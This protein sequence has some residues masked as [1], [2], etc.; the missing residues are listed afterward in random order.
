MR[1]KR[2]LSFAGI[3]ATAVLAWLVFMTLWLWRNQERVVFQPPSVVPPD[4]ETGRRVAFPAA[5]G[6]PTFGFLVQANGGGPKTVV[7]AFHGNADLAVWFIPWAQELSRRAGVTVLVPEYRGYG[8]AAG[9]ATYASA[10]SDALG[11][12]AYA[13]T[14]KPSRVVLYGHS[15]G[16]AIAV[17]LADTMGR[18]QP[19][20]LVLQSPFTSAR[21]MASR[22]LVL[23][24]PMVWDRITR[25][26]WD[27]RASVQRLDI[28]VSVAHGRLDVT[29]PAR[30]GRD[31]FE[32]ARRKG[33]HLV[34]A[35]AGHNDVAEA[36]GEDY[37]RWLT[38]AVTGASA[39][40]GELEQQ[41]RRRLP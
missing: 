37:W 34:V 17:Q 30:M 36:G 3:V 8:G 26:H 39:P 40:V 41:G 4:P 6:S 19:D 29:V 1:V 28:P 21:A 31:V 25:F 10:A 9:S 7:I 38:T 13:R 22:M 16:T 23:V 2:V 14:L 24:P 11:A 33:E 5:D 35:R 18:E 15:L 32:A 12:L 27:T 20:A